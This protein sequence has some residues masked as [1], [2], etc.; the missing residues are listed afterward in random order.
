MRNWTWWKSL[1]L[2]NAENPALAGLEEL[3]EEGRLG[4]L[5]RTL[6]E[7]P[8]ALTLPGAQLPA[9]GYQPRRVAHVDLHPP[10]GL[11]HQL[12]DAVG[13]ALEVAQLLHR[14]ED[15]GRGLDGGAGV[16]GEQALNVA[17]R[18]ERRGNERLDV[19]APEAHFAPAPAGA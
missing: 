8:G 16:L 18:A 14:C 6:V 1:L 5:E 11:L 15:L 19:L 17:R 4:G 3:L 10:L 13:L 9:V 12:F 2:L 7:A